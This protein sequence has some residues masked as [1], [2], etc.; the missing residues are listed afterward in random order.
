MIVR[1]AF[2]LWALA[3]LSTCQQSSTGPTEE[4][5]AT[6]AATAADTSSSA[7]LRSEVAAT[8]PATRQ[9]AA[10]TKRV[11]STPAATT[12]TSSTT[13]TSTTTT[14]TTTEATTTA[15]VAKDELEALPPTLPEHYKLNVEIWDGN[16]KFTVFEHKEETRLALTLMPKATPNKKQGPSQSCL[17]NLTSGSGHV[18]RGVRCHVSTS[19]PHACFCSESQCASYVR[20]E[21]IITF[22]SSGAPGQDTNRSTVQG[23]GVGSV[24]MLSWRRRDADMS[25][26][27][28]YVRSDGHELLPVAA[29]LE[30]SG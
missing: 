1:L 30:G 9:P 22:I 25:V 21:S 15:E 17:V 7:P 18:I 6:R 3:A 19:L 11:E 2:V 8:K 29:R 10:T 4:A 13:P 27:L 20:L 5:K 28:T 24:E 23:A 12:S 16:R 26:E 14:T